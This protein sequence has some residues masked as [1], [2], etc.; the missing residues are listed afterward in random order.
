MPMKFDAARAS[1]IFEKLGDPAF[2]GPDGEGHVADFVAGE[3]ERMGWQVERREVEGSRFPQRAGPW[4]GWLGYG[5]LITVGYVV[6]L[7]KRSR[8]SRR[9]H[10]SDFSWRSGGSDA[11]LS[12]RIRLG[13]RRARSRTAPARA[14]A[15]S[16]GESVP[17]GRGLFSRLFSVGLKTD[18]FQ[19]SAGIGFYN[20]TFK[21]FCLVCMS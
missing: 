15:R 5:A 9:S 20:R 14:S 13:R 6:M 21:R 19:R 18:F 10:Y 3:L 16:T 11:L 2:T 12:N 8:L 7:R 1:A 17:A 4:I